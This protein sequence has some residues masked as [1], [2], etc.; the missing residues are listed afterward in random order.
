MQVSQKRRRPAAHALFF[1]SRIQF[2]AE[3]GLTEPVPT[4]HPVLVNSR[5]RIPDT[6]LRSKVLGAKWRPL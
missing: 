3:T 6:Q 4:P 2:S 5:D 1:P